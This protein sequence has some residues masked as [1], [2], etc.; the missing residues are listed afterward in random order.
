MWRC[1]IPYPQT[2]SNK[3]HLGVSPVAKTKVVRFQ[4]SEAEYSWYYVYQPS[5][6]IGWTK[7]YGERLKS[8]SDICFKTIWK[9]QPVHPIW[10]DLEVKRWTVLNN[11]SLN[12]RDILGN[13]LDPWRYRR[14]RALKVTNLGIY[15][16]LLTK[17]PYIPCSCTAF[18]FTFVE[19]ASSLLNAFLRQPR[20]TEAIVDIS[21]FPT[22]PI[23]SL[24]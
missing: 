1:K 2:I 4:G 15:H 20:E 22:T 11:T 12:K 10:K 5:M 18:H 9:K 21:L 24:P 6:L 3:V 16:H 19:T 13:V 8:G 14:I 23:L 7:T 17:S